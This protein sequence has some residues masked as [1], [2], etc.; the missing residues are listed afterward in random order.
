MTEISGSMAYLACG[1]TDLRNSI[2]GLSA[3]VQGMYGM[4]PFEDGTVFVFCNKTRTNIKIIE[5]E[6]NGF[7]LYQK[8]LERGTF[9]WPKEE[10]NEMMNLSREELNVLLNG[11]KLVQKLKRQELNPTYAY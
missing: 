7:W 4:N 10:D 9:W 6:K 3:R 2:N 11:T 8:R 1:A 5:W